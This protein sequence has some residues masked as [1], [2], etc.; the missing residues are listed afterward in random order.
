MTDQT[1][2]ARNLVPARGVPGERPHD[3]GSVDQR[4]GASRLFGSLRD[5]LLAAGREPTERVET[6]TVAYSHPDASHPARTGN[7]RPS[8]MTADD[9]DNGREPRSQRVS[10]G[11]VMTPQ[12]ASATPMPSLQIPGRVPVNAAEFSGQ[13]PKTQPAPRVP[14]GRLPASVPPGGEARTQLLRGRQK[15]SRAKFHQDPV[16][17]WL[18]VVGGPGLGAHR[19]IYEGNNTVGR[20]PSQR[21]PVDFGDDTISSEEQVYIRYDSHDRSFLF[22]PNLAKTNVVQVNDKKP[23]GAVALQA[24][25]V[26]TMGRTQL[27]FVPFCGPEFDWAELSDV[28]E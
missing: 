11:T 17:G 24:M 28:R 19:S 23:T 13:V 8:S 21:I 10:P 2:G 9:K 3:L 22:V 12:A 1:T 14:A 16:V 7:E 4:N 20:A 26:I 18:V 6:L 25:D 5:A 15:V 27:V